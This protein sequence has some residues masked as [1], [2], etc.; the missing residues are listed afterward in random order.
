MS[1][2]RLVKI[3]GGILQSAHDLAEWGLDTKNLTEND[4][5]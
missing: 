3:V 4:L 1:D 2:E 5:R